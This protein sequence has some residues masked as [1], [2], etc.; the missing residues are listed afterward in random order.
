MCP[1]LLAEC[2][3]ILF[4]AYYRISSHSK[5]NLLAIELTLLQDCDNKNTLRQSGIWFNKKIEI[6]LFSFRHAILSI[7]KRTWN[8]YHRF[9]K[10]VLIQFYLHLDGWRKF[11]WKYL[12]NE[13]THLKFLWFNNVFFFILNNSYS[14][15]PWALAIILHKFQTRSFILEYIKSIATYPIKI[16]HMT[17]FLLLLSI[18]TS[19][20]FQVDRSTPKDKLSLV[21][22]PLL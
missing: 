17:S 13:R 19:N 3:G 6:L 22:V 11:V 21:S 2:E 20:A 18:I 14:K 8:N 7:R 1:Y 15:M 9:K 12:T 10:S 5:W 16:A 4:V